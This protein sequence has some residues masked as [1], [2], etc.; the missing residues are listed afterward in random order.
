MK[1]PRLSHLVRFLSSFAVVGLIATT[2]CRAAETSTGEG[3]AA[4]AAAAKAWSRMPEILARIVP[5]TFPDR[6]FDVT[7]FGGKGDGTTDCTKAFADAIATCHQAGGGR[8]VV[9]EGVFSSGAI[10]LRSGVNLHVGRGA[11]IKFASDPKKYLPVVFTRFE[12]IEVMNY[13]PLIYAFEQE[14]IAVTGEGT[15]D[16]QGDTWQ[17]WVKLAGSDV[18]K[19]NSMGRDKVPV[20]QRV[21]GEG[22][23]LRPNFIQPMRCR[24]VLIEGVRIVNSPMW[25]V[26]PLY[27]TNVT[28]RGISVT[29][30]GKNSDGCDPDSCTDVLIEN[31]TFDTGD[32]CIAI[33]SGRDHDGLRV[34]IPTENV[35]IRNCL[36]KEG[37]G[38]VTMGSET[39]GGIRSVFA[40]DCHFDSPNLDMALRFKTNPARGGFVED[41][42]IRNCTVKTSKYGIHMTLRYGG[43]GAEDDGFPPT[44]KN[45]DIRD[46]KFSILTKGAI[47]IE[48]FSPENRITDV[49]IANCTFETSATKPGDVVTNAAR[50]HLIDNMGVTAGR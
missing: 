22:F 48:G 32:D 24:N 42:F 37:H 11:T 10:H 49:T 36:F 25:V 45:I 23:H 13:S 3:K 41:V 20:A 43:N 34:N 47:F 29:T 18:K 44:M 8:V 38:G 17:A 16:G 6:D 39:S 19:L 26:H 33:K 40:E 1:Q 46:S 30:R 12:C 31:C 7:K 15:L 50:I 9:P 35:V 2:S 27:S 21:F 5:P 14:N 28:V 4:A